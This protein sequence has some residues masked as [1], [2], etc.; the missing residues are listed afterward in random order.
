MYYWEITKD[1]SGDEPEAVGVSGGNKK[2]LER[3]WSLRPFR[4]LDG[5]NIVY[6]EGSFYCT[7]DESNGEE[8][9]SPLDDY[10]MPNAGCTS[11][12][13]WIDGKWVTL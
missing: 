11:I 13:Y 2:T 1:C 7:D 3:S 4:L 12:E 5:D 6:Y 10:G 8:G 9:F